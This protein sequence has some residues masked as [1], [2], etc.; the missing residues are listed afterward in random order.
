MKKIGLKDGGRK[1]SY[2]SMRHSVET[3]LTNQN[4][5]PRMIDGLQGHSQ[6][7][8]GGSV[9]MKGVKPEVLMKECVEKINWDID[10]DK[11]KLDWKKI[12]V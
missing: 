12:I 8:I 1:V 4:V 11:L 2:H 6:K 9:Y 10:F 3:H 5:N 7:G